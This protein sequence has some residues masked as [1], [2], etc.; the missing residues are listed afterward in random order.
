MILTCGWISVALISSALAFQAESPDARAA[1]VKNAFQYAWTNYV[2]HTFGSDEIQPVTG[3]ASNS[4]NGWGASIFDGLD[5]LLIMGLKDEYEQA[6]EH[7]S[8][9]NWRVSNDPSKTFETNIRYLGGLLSAYDLQPNPILLSKALSLADQVIL[10]AFD[11]PNKIPASYVNVTTGKPVPGNQVFL[12][13]FGSMQLELVRLSQI[14]GNSTYQ[15]LGLNIINRLAQV[16]PR[17]P[18]LYPMLWNLESF[19]PSDETI[20][21]NL[22][23]DSVASMETYLKSTTANGTVFLGEINDDLKLLQTGEL[24]CFIGGNI[25]LGARYLNRPELDKFAKDLTDGCMTAWEKMPTGL[26]PEAWS[27]VDESQRLE[28]FPND[29][30]LAMQTFG[31]IPQDKSYDLR[32]ETLESLFYFYRITGDKSYQDK[33]W[34]IFKSIDTY[35]KV[36]YGYSRVLDTTAND[37]FKYLYL[38]FSDPELVSLDKYVFN[39]EAHPFKLPRPIQIQH[40]FS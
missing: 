1:E 8:K 30:R 17:Y 36:Q 34:K 35:C 11:T 23:E 24:I 26:A 40:T 6:L 33:A 3:M 15:E 29:V 7:V 2:N 19:T 27:W 38:I 18:G 12:A 28:T 14:T 16:K 9:V 22:W 13:E 10:P 4:R 39:T 31:F 20:Q 5:T 21:L 32:P 37:T 25:L